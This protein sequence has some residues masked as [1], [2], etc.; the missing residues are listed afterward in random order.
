MKPER[1]AGLKDSV[2]WYYLITIEVAEHSGL[3]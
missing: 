2:S 1:Q 3:V